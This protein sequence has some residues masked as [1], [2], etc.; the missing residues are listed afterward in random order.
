M[1][2]AILLCG[3]ICCGKS[4]YARHIQA[5]RRAVLLSVDQIMLAVFGLYAGERHDEYAARVR[6][7]LLEKSLELLCADVDVILDWGFW[8][9]AGRDQAKE[10]YRSRG[11]DCEM[12]YLDVSQDTWQAR[13]AGRNR[14]VEAGEVT[15][16]IIDGNL[17][18]KFQ[19]SFEPP[20]K[21]EID[22]WIRQ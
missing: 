12:R 9:R 20:T 7:F 22:V 21:E 3:K 2:K 5:E 4:T 17:A 10:F 16:Y 8:T 15:A 18:R 14:A 6:G 13:I 11:I 19:R 1:A